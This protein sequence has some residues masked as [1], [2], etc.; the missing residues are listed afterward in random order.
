MKLRADFMKCLAT[1]FTCA[2]CAISI[3]ATT[4]HVP[5]DQPTIQAGIDAA[6]SGDTVLVADGTYTVVGNRDISF[7][8]KLATPARD[9]RLLLCACPRASLRITHGEGGGP[10][11]KRRSTGYVRSAAF[12]PLLSATFVAHLRDR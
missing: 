7:G 1:L 11:R 6:G 10:P 12:I 4:I 3:N 5:G 2:F 9:G 8:G